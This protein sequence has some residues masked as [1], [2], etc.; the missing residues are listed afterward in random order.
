MSDSTE[1]YCHGDN[2]YDDVNTE[3]FFQDEKAPDGEAGMRYR[4][5]A[6]A[7][8]LQ[9]EHVFHAFSDPT[10]KDPSF[11]S[12]DASPLL[13]HAINVKTAPHGVATGASSSGSGGQQALPE[14]PFGLPRTHFI[15]PGSSM[16]IMRPQIDEYL[17]GLLDMD[18]TFIPEQH[19]WKGK[20]LQGA[21]CFEMDVRAFQE[22]GSDDITF[23]VLKSKCD[24]RCGKFQSF[25]DGFSASLT[26]E[27]PAKKAR[28][29]MVLRD[30]PADFAVPTDEEFISGIEPVFKMAQEACMEP[31]LEA[32]KMLCDLSS[33]EL[34]FLELEAF[35]SDC[36]VVLETLVQDNFN[37]V[38]QHTI[39]AIS[40]FAEIESYQEGIITSRI[41][42]V[43][44]ALIDNSPSSIPSF[45]TAQIRRSAAATIALLCQKHAGPVRAQLMN[46]FPVESWAQRMVPAIR[47]QRTRASAQAAAELLLSED[48][49]AFA[50]DSAPAVDS[51]LGSELQSI[52]R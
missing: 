46:M 40:K 1:K 16:H 36:I 37:D 21:C 32:A 43:L 52:V 18:F 23:A 24:A 44:F 49:V 22:R 38:K 29:G 50:R 2:Y 51:V 12:S 34:H 41:L 11:K 42:P 39:M 17:G 8:A 31:R 20:Y 5:L 6:V 30:L 48:A 26:G 15:V 4:S 13:S 47:D 27:A 10:A 3:E 33:K 7:P 35:R 25:Y 9:Q 19:M 14:P 28:R 45:E